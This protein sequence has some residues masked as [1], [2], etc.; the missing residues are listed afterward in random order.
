MFPTSEEP[1]VELSLDGATLDIATGSRG[2]PARFE[3]T[4]ARSEAAAARGLERRIATLRR[5]GY[6][7]DDTVERALPAL[8]APGDL[9]TLEA[10]HAR[11][12]ATFKSALPAFLT[13]WRAQGFSIDVAFAKACV[14]NTLHPNEVAERCL[15]L[16]SR[17]F[18]VEFVGV[19]R[20]FDEAH[21]DRSRVTRGLSST[22]YES[23]LNVLALALRKLQGHSRTSDDVE[24]PGLTDEIAALIRGLR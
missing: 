23:P 6:L 9:D 24:A 21:G 20:A 14:G 11:G 17:T 19:T 12:L 5:R 22:F 10:R 2:K 13:E 1:Y 7:A 16:A 8:P 4:V 18:E 15:R 3:R